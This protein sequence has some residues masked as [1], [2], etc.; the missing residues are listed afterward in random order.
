MELAR[1]WL[2]KPNPYQMLVQQ[3]LELE[4]G[5]LSS[6]MAN[7]ISSLADQLISF[8]AFGKAT[9]VAETF[10]LPSARPQL[11]VQTYVNEFWTSKQRAASSLHEISYRA[12]FKPQLP[13]FFIERLTESGDTVHDP[14][15]GRGTTVIEAALLGRVPSG[16]DISPLSVVLTRPRL[17]PP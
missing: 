10:G 3:N 2:R 13:H 8:R 14:F 5:E 7:T 17:E 4:F 12:C 9:Q 15:M 11:T 16:C 1:S 6:P